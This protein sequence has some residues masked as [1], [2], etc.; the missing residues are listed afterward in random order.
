[1]KLESDPGSQK[2]LSRPVG[3]PSV[4]V[5]VKG[6]EAYSKSSSVMISQENGWWGRTY[7]RRLVIE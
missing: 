6:G 1:M 5:Q 7:F 2:V 4:T 3:H